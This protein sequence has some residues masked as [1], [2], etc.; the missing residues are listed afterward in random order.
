MPDHFSSTYLLT[1][2]GFWVTQNRPHWVCGLLFASP[3]IWTCASKW[4]FALLNHLEGLTDFSNAVIAKIPFNSLGF[5][6]KLI[7][8]PQ[9]G[10]LVLLILSHSKFFNQNVFTQFD[11]GVFYC[12]FWVTFACC[13]ERVPQSLTECL[14]ICHRFWRKFP[15]RSCKVL[16]QWQHPWSRG[17]ASHTH[18]WSEGA[19]TPGMSFYKNSLAESW[20]RMTAKASLD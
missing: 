19:A 12:H 10:K 20:G 7:F 8:S 11:C 1:I 18:C 13:Q 6:S 4:P 15:K 9:K 2:L 17:V 5:I 16:W 3:H 14:I